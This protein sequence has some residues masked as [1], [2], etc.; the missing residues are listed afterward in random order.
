MWSWLK[1][2]FGGRRPKLDHSAEMVLKEEADWQRLIAEWPYPLRLVPGTEATAAWFEE[3]AIGAREGFSP[4][5]IT[6]R[7]LKIP[8]D[9][10]EIADEDIASPETIVDTY[11][12]K[13]LFESWALD[14]KT[15]PYDI[16]DASPEQV[17]AA[18]A[19][20]EDYN[21]GG[22]YSFDRE[23]FND[24]QELPP[25]APEPQPQTEQFNDINSFYLNAPYPQVAITRLPTADSWR[26]PLLLGLGGWNNC[27]DTAAL[28]A[29]ARRWKLL[30]GAE[31]AA[32]TFD[33]LE[34]VVARP[35]A[36][37]DEATR[38]AKEHYIAGNEVYFEQI[39]DYIAGLRTARRWYF[40]WD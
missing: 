4:I 23:F 17:A 36:T 14:N 7:T 8:K 40:W 35:P 11:V 1:G 12:R 34:F 6:P 2:L 26:I 33:T 20:A 28:A 31:L 27:P 15:G 3:A 21:R 18:L 32:V 37:F 19:E 10:R 25:D 13:L 24:V 16:R 9:L 5:L 38:L 29:F 22:A 30:Y 39:S